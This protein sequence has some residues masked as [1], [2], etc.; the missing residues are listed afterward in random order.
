M[1]LY[2]TLCMTYCDSLEASVVR[3][4]VQYQ[5]LGNLVAVAMDEDWVEPMVMEVMKIWWA[6]CRPV[7]R[8]AFS[9]SKSLVSNISQLI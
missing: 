3:S 2:T 4:D 5:A 7:A 1:H 8:I 9:S 6:R